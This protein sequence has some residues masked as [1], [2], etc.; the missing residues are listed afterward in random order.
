MKNYF[1][2]YETE[3]NCGCGENNFSEKTRLRLNK[4][5]E[6]AGI[7]FG[8]SSACRCKTHNKAEGGK[9]TSSHISDVENQIECEAVDIVVTSS[10]AR[11]KI[12]HSL[13][14]EGF[15]RIGIGK[16]FIHADTDETKAP[17]VSWL[18]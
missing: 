16:T 18:Y 5:R 2:D 9:E 13:I 17:K 10:R 8:L 14:A 15:T 6:R 3:C 1:P 4:A 12:L 7:P 11:F